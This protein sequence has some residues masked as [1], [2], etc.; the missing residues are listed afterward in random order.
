MNDQGRGNNVKAGKAEQAGRSQLID[1]KWSEGCGEAF[2]STDPVSDEVLWQGNAAA[3]SDVSRAIDVARKAQHKWFAT[4][5]EER[6]AIVERFA[7][8]VLTHR[9]M[10]AE[11]IAR[12]TG[13]PLWEADGE[14]AAMAAKVGITLKAVEDRRSDQVNTSSAITS[15]VRYKPH[16]VLAV[17][18]PFN[19]P[20]HLPNGHIVPALLAGNTVVFKPSELTPLV[21]QRTAEI[22]QEAGLPPGV[23]N[24][25]Q[26]GGDTGRSLAIHDGIDGLLFTGGLETGLKL[27]RAFADFPQRIL[28]LELGGNNPLIVADL[29]DIDA[30]VYATIV[31]AYATS[32]Q[33][34]SCAR[35]LIVVDSDRRQ[36]FVDR[37]IYCLHRVTV[38]RYNDE[39]QPFMGSVISKHAA[40]RVLAFADRL[41]SVGGRVCL[42]VKQLEAPTL[43]TPGLIDMT[44]APELPDE[45]CFGPLLQMIRVPDFEGAIELANQTKYGLAAGLLCDDRDKYEQFLRESRAGIVNWNR[46]LTGASSSLPFG[47]VGCSGNHRPSGYFAVDYCSYPVASLEQAHVQPGGGKS[48]P[49]LENLFG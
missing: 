25:L 32:G 48:S 14:A 26:G 9:D 4:A 42:P 21:A 47:G 31:S 46:P 38:G 30:A 12:E 27:H 17:L 16:G 28:A 29:V 44:S 35:R 11:T 36:G 37:L 1:G 2:T 40:E 10:L 45:E 43:L 15:A 3:G 33:R 23:L 39:P 20:G 41:E 6:T 18:G 34:C 13:K 49:G 7:A 24:L 22:W 5:Y 8:L 19:F